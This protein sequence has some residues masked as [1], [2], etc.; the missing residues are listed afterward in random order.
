MKIGE[1]LQ[2]EGKIS[3]EQLNHAL[4][5][6]KKEPGKLGSVLIRLGFVTEEDIAQALSKQFGYPSI[7]LS[8][9]DVGERVLEL[10]KPEIARK[11]VVMP[12]HRIGSILTLAMA[13]P[14]NLFVQEEIRFSTN[15]RIQAVIAPESSI[16]EAI[17]RYYGSSTGI[18]AQK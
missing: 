17:D 10:I 9:F 5:V 7:N 3:Q 13:D 2:Q 4:E 15:L 11:H 8:K 16:L 6:Q 18:E 12:V 1:F 14:S